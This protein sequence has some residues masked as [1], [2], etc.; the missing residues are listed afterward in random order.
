MTFFFKEDSLGIERREKL[1]LPTLLLNRRCRMLQASKGCISASNWVLRSSVKGPN[2]NSVDELDAPDPKSFINFTVL[3]V[4]IRVIVK[5]LF[6]L[7]RV[8]EHTI[9]LIFSAIS[10][11]ASSLASMFTILRS[12]VIVTDSRGQVY[13]FL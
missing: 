9:L 12:N 8:K 7:R 6:S 3:K 13:H 10:D 1:I 4:I 5:S 11:I 2:I